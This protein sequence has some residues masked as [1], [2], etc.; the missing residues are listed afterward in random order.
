MDNRCAVADLPTAARLC[1]FALTRLRLPT[2]VEIEVS[3][4]SRI[5]GPPAG[6]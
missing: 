1:T 6:P 2:A 4:G 5:F 3:L